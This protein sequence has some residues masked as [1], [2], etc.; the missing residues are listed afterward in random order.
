M[1]H[2]V[3][4]GHHNPVATTAVFSSDVHLPELQTFSSR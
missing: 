1:M 2:L 4:F 3:L